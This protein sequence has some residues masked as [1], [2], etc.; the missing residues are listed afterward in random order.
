MWEILGDCICRGLFFIELCFPYRLIY[1]IIYCT[2]F[3]NKFINSVYE[4]IIINLK[5]KFTLKNTVFVHF[6]KEN[7]NNKS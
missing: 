2:C 7:I 4:F 3:Y 1:F 5:T 6:E